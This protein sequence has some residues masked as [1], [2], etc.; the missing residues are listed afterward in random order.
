[1][2]HLKRTFDYEPFFKEFAGRLQQEGLLIPL[3]G[4]DDDD[5]KVSRTR[6][7][8]SAAGKGMTMNEKGKQKM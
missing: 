7:T 3:L 4:L 8:T 2:D 5:G 6:G 1:M